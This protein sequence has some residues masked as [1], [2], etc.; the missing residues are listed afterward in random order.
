VN[1]SKIIWIQYPGYNEEMPMILKLKDQIEAVKSPLENFS[2]TGKAWSYNL[3]NLKPN[4]MAAFHHQITGSKNIKNSCEDFINKPIW[5][6]LNFQGFKS[7]VLEKST[8]SREKIFWPNCFEQ[9]DFKK[10]L[11]Y[12]HMEKANDKNSDFFNAEEPIVSM[13]VGDYFDRACQSGKCSNSL[14]DNVKALLEKSLM[15]EDK[16]LFI[17]R[18]FSLIRGLEQ[19]KDNHSTIVNSLQELSKVLA[20]LNILK[21]SNPEIMIILTSGQSANIDIPIKD[22]NVIAKNNYSYSAVLAKGAGAENFCGYFQ[23]DDIFKRILWKSGY[24]F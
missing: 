6:L 13:K 10:N 5:A 17:I 12:F 11:G 1:A 15:K 24:N 9:A 22:N 7:A 20:Y 4:P 18:D 21:D 16:F 14:Y 3:F 19:V 23:H 8:N 2:C